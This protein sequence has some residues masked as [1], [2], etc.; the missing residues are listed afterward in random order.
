[1]IKVKGSAIGFWDRVKLF[2]EL[3]DSIKN[4][5]TFIEVVVTAILWVVVVYGFMLIMPD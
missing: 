4:M 2:I 3:N 1:M 5:I